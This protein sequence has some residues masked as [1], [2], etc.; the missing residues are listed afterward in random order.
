M[1]KKFWVFPIEPDMADGVREIAVSLQQ[2]DI[3]SSDLDS[4]RRRLV[5]S[6]NQIIDAGFEFYY[7]RPAEYSSL[8]AVVQGAIQSIIYTIRQSIHMVVQRVFKSMS[9]EDLRAMANY[10]DSMV[11]PPRDQGQPALLAHPLG[12]SLS[13]RIDELMDTIRNSDSVS[14]YD[15][16]LYRTFAEVVE[17][18]VR[19]YYREPTNMVSLNP[20]AK[21]AADLGINT[22][23]SGVKKIL[24]RVVREVKH[25]EV[26]V[27][28][29]NIDF[30]VEERD[31]DYRVCDPEFIETK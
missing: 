13:R 11:L 4:L 30:L 26:S 6:L 18:S 29:D 21:K 9:L 20:I 7:Q 2:D 28:P 3:G 15:G 24:K 17:V 25:E 16:E 27:L 10:L 1:G 23:I 22:T 12:D 31:L 8:N 19:F 5:R 14:E